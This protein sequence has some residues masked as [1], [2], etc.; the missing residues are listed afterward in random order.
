VT[1]AI[2]ALQRCHYP[3]VGQLVS[4]GVILSPVGAANVQPST[5]VLGTAFD[6][7]CLFPHPTM[8]TIRPIQIMADRIDVFGYR[9]MSDIGETYASTL[10][11]NAAAVNDRVIFS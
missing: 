7:V 10:V 4:A 11:R 8:E 3:Y 1:A 6:F 2:P 5:S 9:K